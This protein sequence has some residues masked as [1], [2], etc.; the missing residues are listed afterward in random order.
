MD[1]LLN[2]RFPSKFILES[3]INRDKYTEYV[4]DHYDIQDREKC[5][6][7]VP[8][9]TREDIQEM[10]DSQWNILLICGN[11]GSGKSTILKNLCGYDGNKIEYTEGLSCVSQ[12]PKLSEEEVCDMFCGVGLSSVPTWLRKPNELSN[13][14][15]ARLDL[16]MTMH[17]A[18]EERP[19]VCIDEFTSTVN[20]SAA[21]SMS[22]AFQRYLRQHN[23]R[24]VIASCHFDVIEYLRPDYVFNLNKRDK[25]GNVEMEKMVY[26]DDEKYDEYLSVNGTEILSEAMEME[27]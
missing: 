25:D 15:R 7:E 10:M 19:F 18:M 26:K 9:P 17:N 16:C 21:K 8:F 1:K 4:C 3:N 12:F 5:M 14:E 20:R 2:L 23:M 13:G 11:S 24:A 22:F 6:T 27:G